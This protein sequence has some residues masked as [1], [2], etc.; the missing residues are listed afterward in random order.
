MHA[1]RSVLRLAVPA[2]AAGLLD[3]GVDSRVFP[4]LDASGFEL[5]GAFRNGFLH[6]GADCALEH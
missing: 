5:V 1:M 2:V 6:G 3:H 4:G